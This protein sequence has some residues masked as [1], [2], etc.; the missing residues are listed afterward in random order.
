[1]QRSDRSPADKDNQINE[2]KCPK[3][4]KYVKIR[5]LNDIDLGIFVGLSGKKMS[6][7]MPREE[8][9]KFRTVINKLT[10]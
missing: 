8:F 2:Q 10:L 5:K 3:R 7:P 1:M 4:F 9:Y 6:A